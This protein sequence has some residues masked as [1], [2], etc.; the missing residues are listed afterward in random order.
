MKNQK[1]DEFINSLHDYMFRVAMKYMRDFDKAEDVTQAAWAEG[2]KTV[3]FSRTDAEVRDYMINAVKMVVFNKRKKCYATGT[4]LQ[5]VNKVFSFSDV[6]SNHQEEEIQFEAPYEEIGYLAV[7]VA[8][9]F[10]SVMQ[11]A[12]KKMDSIEQTFVRLVLDGW[13][14]VEA[15]RHCGHEPE[16][17]WGYFRLKKFRDHPSVKKYFAV[18]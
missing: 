12:L 17:R 18:S 11:D 2:L 5:E 6:A 4:M 13:S 9:D 16:E 3:D 7:E 1:S 10:M 14:P 8:N 15:S